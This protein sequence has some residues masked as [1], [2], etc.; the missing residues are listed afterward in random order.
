MSIHG[1]WQQYKSNIC[2]DSE[3]NEHITRVVATDSL[4]FSRY[5]TR[6]RQSST[7]KHRLDVCFGD[8]GN[9]RT[10]KPKFEVTDWPSQYH[11][12]LGRPTFAWFMAV[13]HYAYLVL[14]SWGPWESSRSKEVLKYQIPA[15]GNST[16]WHKL[17]A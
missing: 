9:F 10:E 4:L 14:K 13:A 2:K 7:R 11:A 16:R 17:P 12:I 1:C 5:S 8:R 15:I 3:G 6:K